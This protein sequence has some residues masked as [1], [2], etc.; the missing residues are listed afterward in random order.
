[1]HGEGDTEYKS[2]S[3][4]LPI[5]TCLHIDIL[6]NFS[7]SYKFSLSHSWPLPLSLSLSRPL[8]SSHRAT[9]DTGNFLQPSFPL[10]QLSVSLRTVST[11]QRGVKVW[12]QSA[13]PVHL[14]LLPC[15]N[16]TMRHLDCCPFLKNECHTLF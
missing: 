8:F 13:S 4:T 12:Y 15:I 5:F 7:F 1:M 2:S 3:L 11:P 14:S 9:A 10:H 6:R 16:P